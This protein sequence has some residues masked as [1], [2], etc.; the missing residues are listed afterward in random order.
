M[1][2]PSLAELPPAPFGKSA[3]PWTIE[4]PRLPPTRPNGSG[5]PRISIVTPS[6]NQGRYIEETIRS[7]LLQG[8]HNL[9]YYVLDAG[10]TDQTA[11]IIQHYQALLT[12]WRSQPDA[13]QAAA[14]NEGLARSSGDLFQWINS[15]DILEMGALK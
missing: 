13:G 4:T 3:W 1:R 12:G 15:D 11:A 6:C 8:Y 14:L 7:V 2:C 5:W 10:S 9:E